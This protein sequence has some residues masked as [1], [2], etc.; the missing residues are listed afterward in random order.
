M[1]DTTPTTPPQGGATGTMLDVPQQPQVQAPVPFTDDAQQPV[2][3]TDNPTETPSDAQSSDTGDQANPQPQSNTPPTPQQPQAQQGQPQQ[4]SQGGQQQPNP[5]QPKAQGAMPNGTPAAPATNPSVQRAGWLHTVAETLAGG[6]RFKTSIDPNTGVMTRTKVPL[7]RG[8]IGM[9]IVAE[10]LGGAMAGFSVKNGPGN[11]GRAAAAG[12]QQGQEQQQQQRQQQM[13]EANQNYARAAAITQANFQTHANALKMSLMDQDYHE[14]FVDQQKPILD[15]LNAVGA[16]L[17]TNVKEQDLLSKYH[18]TKDMAVADGVVPRID[19]NTGEQAKNPDGS[20][21]WDNT[22]SVIDP[23]AQ[24]ELPDETRKFLADHM[25]K[26]FT[27]TVDGKPVAIDLPADTRLRA[28]FVVG[29]NAAAQSVKLTEDSINNQLQGLGKEGEADAQK[30]QVNLKEAL[31]SGA[32]SQDG[33]KTFAKYATLPLDQ[34]PDAMQKDKVRP[35]IIGQVRALIPQD[36]MEQLKQQRVA[37]EEKNK[38]DAK[39]FTTDT[40]EAALTDPTASPERKAQAQ[41]FLKTDTQHAANKDASIASAKTTAEL[42]AKDKFDKSHASPLLN[43]YANEIPTNG[44]RQGFM[45]AL[46]QSDPLKANNVQ[47]FLEGRG[48][49]S[50][51][52]VGRKEGEAFMALVNTAA[53][54]FDKRLVNSYNEAN[55]DFTSGKTAGQIQ[56]ANNSLEHLGDYFSA[57][58]RAGAKAFLP[59]ADSAIGRRD[60]DVNMYFQARDRALV[61]LEKAYN[62]GAITDSAYKHAVG[63]MSA[64]SPKEAMNNARSATTLLMAP[65]HSWDSRLAMSMPSSVVPERDYMSDTAH[66]A[67]KTIMGQDAD[68]TAAQKAKRSTP[69]V[70]NSASNP[71][72]PVD[73][74]LAKVPAGAFPGR[75]AQGQIIG[76]KTADGKTVMF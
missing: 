32:L 31:A 60:P 40:A 62:A 46:R 30:F 1:V 23:K 19:P 47:A 56:A 9:A 28:S 26:G 72:K 12:Y 24:I 45:S 43:Q 41:A 37:A 58:Q 11:L 34:I 2:P 48:T 64:S 42:N 35:D 13:D 54:D 6:P 36:A 18:V 39:P 29:A 59:G 3:F 52:A 49:L 25:V 38:N 50:D 8:D 61:E 14:K 5:Q 57:V 22:Y 16:V 71:S 15:N 70:G 65:W 20:D 7:S 73:P 68:T 17:A 4:G 66:A 75:N 67:Y 69:F 21:A 33:M 63:L 51:Y 74:N 76:Y 27:K 55:K 44:I 10:V 53:P